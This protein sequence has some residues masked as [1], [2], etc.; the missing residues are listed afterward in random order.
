MT[1]AFILPDI[2]LHTRKDATTQDVLKTISAAHDIKNCS[3]CQRILSTSPVDLSDLDIPTPVP[4]TTRPAYQSDIDATLRPSQPPS[5]ALSRVIKEL[6]DELHHLKL[7]FTVLTQKLRTSDPVLGKRASE[8]LHKKIERL[9]NA[10]R[11][12]GAQLYALYDV[13]EAHKVELEHAEDGEEL[14]EDVERTLESI[15]VA[16]GKKVGFDAEGEENESEWP[17]ISDTE[18]L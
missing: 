17:G 4:V 8:A 18:G 14:P 6:S 11:V 10:I 15:R 9:N 12:K 3:V 5:Q 16:R 7:E 2:T 1:S 13:C